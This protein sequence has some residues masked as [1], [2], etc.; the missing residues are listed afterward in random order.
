MY[1]KGPTSGVIGPD[2]DG[3][4][5]Q[6]SDGHEVPAWCS[7]LARLLQFIHEPGHGSLQVHDLKATLLTI[8][9][10]T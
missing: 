9:S 5:I 8:W 4:G 3:F 10:I 1:L 2:K 6:T 7:V